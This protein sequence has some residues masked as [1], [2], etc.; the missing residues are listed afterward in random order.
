MRFLLILSGIL[1]PF[2]VLAQGDDTV[3]R[4]EGFLLLWR[5]IHRPAY[6]TRQ[7]TPFSDVEE[8]EP[9]YLEITYAKRRKILDNKDLFYPENPLRMHDAL[10]WLF[11]TRNVADITD[12]QRHHV[13]DLLRRFPILP[14]DVSLEQVVHLNQIKDLMYELDTFLRK[15]VHEVSY[16]ADDFHGKGTAFGETF[17][18][19]DLTAAHRTLP[20]DTLVRVTN[21]DNRQNVIVRINDR[22]PYVDGR[23]MDMSLAAFEKISP[24]SRGLLRATFQ[25]LGNDQLS[26]AC[27]TGASRYQKR[28]TRDVR[29]HRG[30]PHFLQRGKTL[31]LGANKHFVVHWVTYPDGTRRRFQ[32]FVYPDE[33]FTFK[34]SIL[35]EYLFEI[36]TIDGRKR[37]MTTRV[38]ECGE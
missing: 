29:L 25:R 18:M 11:R 17:N 27:Q 37:I 38:V 6:E 28:I 13:R 12:M 24:R 8:G 36:G 19:H 4:R 14:S 34:P 31:W 1:V 35:G 9:G 33:R 30:V 10:L 16:Y 7:I 5:S 20:H 32:D 15:E 3:T 2:V 22:G 23:D 26:W 21:I